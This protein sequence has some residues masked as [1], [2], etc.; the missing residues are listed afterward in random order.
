[1]FQ[2]QLNSLEFWFEGSI[3]NKSLNTKIVRII[4]VNGKPITW[5]NSDN[6][7]YPSTDDELELL[8]NTGS[9]NFI[10][11]VKPKQMKRKIKKHPG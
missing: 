2:I 1:M 4:K 6:L 9:E 10:Y 11:N 7:L 8:V 5:F 3:I